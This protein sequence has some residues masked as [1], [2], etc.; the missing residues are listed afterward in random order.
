MVFH[1]YHLGLPLD[2]IKL[3]K[4]YNELL[5]YNNNV[6]KELKID[7]KYVTINITQKIISFVNI[8]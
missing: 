5:S 8:N 6:I 4:R 3:T 1:L 7:L 2:V